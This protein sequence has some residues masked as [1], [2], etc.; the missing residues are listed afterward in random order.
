MDRLSDLE[1]FIRLVKQGSLASLAREL[2]VTPPAVTSR[3]AQLERRL[4]VRLL[5]RTTRRI[6]V[7]HEGRGS[8]G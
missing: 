2:G 5:N 1:F 3:L 8:A 6:S 4:G 7:T